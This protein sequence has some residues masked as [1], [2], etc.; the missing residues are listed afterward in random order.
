MGNKVFRKFPMCAFL[1]SI[2]RTKEP[3]RRPVRNIAIKTINGFI[4]K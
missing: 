2:V 1:L 3:E 4:I